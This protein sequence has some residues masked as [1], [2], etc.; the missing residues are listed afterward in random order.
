MGLDVFTDILVTP[1]GDG[2]TWAAVAVILAVAGVTCWW[3]RRARQRAYNGRLAAVEDRASQNSA[4]VIQI[5][6]IAERVCPDACDLK[7]QAPALRL[8][9]GA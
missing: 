8:V 5:L 2:P 9:K 4:A 1:H 3:R 6:H 7:Q